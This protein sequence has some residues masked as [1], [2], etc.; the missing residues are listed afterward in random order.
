MQP[1]GQAEKSSAARFSVAFSVMPSTTVDCYQLPL[2]IVDSV[3]LRVTVGDG[4]KNLAWLDYISVLIDA[5]DSKIFEPV[6]RSCKPS[7][8]IGVSENA[9]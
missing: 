8:A 3:W 6:P 2:T 4:F 9:A 1:R 7:T 5:I